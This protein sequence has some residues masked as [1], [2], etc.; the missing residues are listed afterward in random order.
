ML[1]YG[2][3][4]PTL[5]S[6]FASNLRASFCFLNSAKSTELANRG[7]ELYANSVVT[8]GH[9]VQCEGKSSFKST[10]GSGG[11]ARCSSQRSAG[12][13]LAV[14][15]PPLKAAAFGCTQAAVSVC[16]IHHFE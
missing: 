8:S 10:N 3:L 9:G 16:F 11:V 2:L 14:E 7:G 4:G 6:V 12:A 15:D 13:V 1:L 5:N